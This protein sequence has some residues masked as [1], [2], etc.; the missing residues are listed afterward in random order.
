MTRRK[1]RCCGVSACGGEMGAE[2]CRR[3]DVAAKRGG[4]ASRRERSYGF[5]YGR[6]APEARQDRFLISAEA[7]TVL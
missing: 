3:I 4:D 1:M 5:T 7:A 6:P 2:L